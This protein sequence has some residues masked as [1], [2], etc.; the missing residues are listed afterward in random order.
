MVEVEPAA[1]VV[2]EHSPCTHLC[3]EPFVAV[4]GADAIVGAYFVEKVAEPVLRSVVV[5]AQR[6]VADVIDSLQVAV[7]VAQGCTF[8]CGHDV[9]L[10]GDAA[11][12]L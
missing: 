12:Q 9:A 5:A 4:G 6:E 1:P 10:Q 3:I 7:D 11:L 8:V 2:L